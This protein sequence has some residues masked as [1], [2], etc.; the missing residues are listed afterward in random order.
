[1]S[2]A[3]DDPDAP[4]AELPI[5]GV[6]EREHVVTVF[7]STQAHL[8]QERSCLHELFQQHAR[9]QPDALCLA[10]GDATL[11]YGEVNHPKPRPQTGCMACLRPCACVPA[12]PVRAHLQR[13]VLRGG[14]LAAVCN[15][16][17]ACLPDALMAAAAAQVDARTNQLAHHLIAQGVSLGS[18]VGLLLEPSADAVIAMLAVLK[19]G[20]CYVP[21]QQH[22]SDA[23]LALIAEDASL[24]EVIAHRGLQ[25]RLP[26]GRKIK[27]VLLDDPAEEAMVWRRPARCPGRRAAPVDA[28]FVLFKQAADAVRPTGIVHQHEGLADMIDGLVHMAGS[29]PSEVQPRVPLASPLTEHAAALEVWTPLTQGGAL[30]VARPEFELDATYFAGLLA[31][32]GATAAYF[33]AELLE[34]AVETGALAEAAR[35]LRCLWVS[36]PLRPGAAE[37]LFALLP[38][39]WLVLGYGLLEAT[40]FV[41]AAVL[42]KG[43]APVGAPIGR[44]LVNMR[45]RPLFSQPGGTALSAWFKVAVLLSLPHRSAVGRMLKLPHSVT[46]DGAA[47]ALV[48]DDLQ[49]PVPVGVP[50][51][52]HVS[53]TCLARGYI[54]LPQ[55][56]AERFVPNPLFDAYADDPHFA[57]MYRSG[58]L[59]AWQPDGS[60]RYV[61]PVGDEVRC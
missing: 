6:T 40:P 9:R 25:R 48:L 54:G 10:C 19:A 21:L 35:T 58:D 46:M 17:R 28:A 27:V 34:S 1:M 7:N 30:V 22:R 41:T 39:A 49:N 15:V 24:A 43:D 5:M 11:T 12:I 51:E 31:S 4:A 53:G 13:L 47:Q 37:A 36:D 50:G 18:A 60:L 3:A 52:L 59:V 32:A 8:A 23:A 56:T 33:T 57:K 45:A 38:D 16:G 26:A 55:L 14:L 44:P 20:C 61:G 29:G 42:R 2:V